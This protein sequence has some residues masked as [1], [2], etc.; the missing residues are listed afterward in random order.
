MKKFQDHEYVRV[1]QVLGP[2][3]D[4]SKIPTDILE[5]ASERGTLVHDL[6]ELYALDSLIEPIDEKIKGYFESFKKWFDKYV[7]EVI[8]VEER[9]YDDEYLFT[10]KY[11]LLCR[12][13]DDIT[14]I[15]LVDY[16]TPANSFKTWQL[17][18]AAYMLL[19]ESK[20]ISLDRRLCL[21]LRKDGSDSNVIEYTNHKQDKDLFIKSL[22]LYRFFN[23]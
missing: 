3:S 6:C 7:Y 14:K 23:S 20:N 21:Q 4:F 16:K 13:K 5:A 17:Q 18:S 22:E 10:G 2:Y 19:L 15:V 12:L 11:D 8:S 1:T 9:L